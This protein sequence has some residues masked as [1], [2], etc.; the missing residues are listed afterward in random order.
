MKKCPK[1]GAGEFR[2]T[3]HVTQDWL[4]DSDG[5]YLETLEPFVE[6]VY[7]P[8]DDDIWECNKCGYDAAGRE[9]NVTD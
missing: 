8:N 7:E 5:D 3:V 9:F 6:T 1:C 2:I 4:V